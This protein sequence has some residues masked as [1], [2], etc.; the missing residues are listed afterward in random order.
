MH[1]LG[2]DTLLILLS[3][4]AVYPHTRGHDITAATA[5]AGDKVVGDGPR[6]GEGCP[7]Y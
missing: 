1:L 7:G 5:H 6:S 3:L 2:M 4:R